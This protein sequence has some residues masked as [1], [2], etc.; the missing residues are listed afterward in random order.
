MASLSYA[1][2]P[3]CSLESTALEFAMSTKALCRA[4]DIELRE[5]DDWVCCGASAAHIRSD[6]L[7]T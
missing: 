5:V 1:F 7:R 2:F 3:G 6:L 4:L